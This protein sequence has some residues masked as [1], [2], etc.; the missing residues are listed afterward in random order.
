MVSAIDIPATSLALAGLPIPK[1][2]DGQSFLGP[3]AKFR[4]EIFGAR[5]RC[6]ETVDRIRSVRTERYKLIRN[7]YPERPYT[8][9]NAYK[10]K[11]YPVLNLMKQLHAAGK[12]TPEQELFMAPRRP[13]EELYDL[14]TDPDEIHNL[15]GDVAHQK[16]QD[17]LRARLDRWIADT[18]DRG[19]I[20]ENPAVIDK[21]K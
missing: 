1:R 19:A 12:L 11:Q 8:Q 6:D 13:A 20:P 9:P 4:S 16:I 10:E 3:H 17:E 15:A 14:E 21:Q 2:M 5:D 7:Y 18:H